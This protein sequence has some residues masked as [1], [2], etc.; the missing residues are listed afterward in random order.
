MI[1]Q[2]CLRATSLFVLILGFGDAVGA[3]ALSPGEH[4]K[5]LLGHP[6]VTGASVSAGYDVDARRDP[7][8]LSPGILAALSVGTPRASIL[9]KAKDGARGTELVPK[10]PDSDYNSC[11]LVIG[12]DLFFWDSVPD[13]GANV[14]A[15]CARRT[16]IVSQFFARLRKAHIPI[17]IGNIPNLL[18]TFV[19]QSC[20]DDLN[21][22]I[23]SECQLSGPTRC[24]ILDLRRIHELA[25][26]GQLVIGDR[27]VSLEDLLPDGLHLSEL[28]A[29]YIKDRILDLSAGMALRNER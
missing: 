15:T 6:L 11:S 4:L 9:W 17:V 22:R 19:S 26:K 1:L 5:V 21:A 23:V 18:G 20:A 14:R 13:S 12:V 2:K 10:L 7:S 25:E 28:S 3:G 27:H 8:L 29:N 16:A 24:R